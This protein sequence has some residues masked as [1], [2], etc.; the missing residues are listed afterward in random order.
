MTQTR[1][2]F[3]AA[4][5]R[6]RQLFAAMERSFEDDGF[7]LAIL[8]IDETADRHELSVYTPTPEADAA[9]IRDLFGH[10]E[11]Y[12]VEYEAL[13]D[14]DWVAKSLEGLPPVRAGRYLV[15]G[16]HDRQARK[17]SDIAIEIDAGQ[18]FGTGHHE[19]TA[20]CLNAIAS[21]AKRVELRNVLDLGTGSAVLAIALAKTMPVKVLAT[22]IDP[23]ATLVANSNIRLNGVTRQVSA[24]TANGFNASVVSACAPFDLIIANVLAGPLMKLAPAMTRHTKPGGTIILSGILARQRWPVIAAYANQRFKH[25]A[26]T[27]SGEWVTIQLKR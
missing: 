26:T 16:S 10:G 3:I 24:L 6:A 9:K 1:L 19:T 8:E 13:P 20:G 7:P 21:V 14:I 27:W 2:H 4:G 17:I 23:I 22:D 15:H 25:V 18:A 12:E 5:D 11:T